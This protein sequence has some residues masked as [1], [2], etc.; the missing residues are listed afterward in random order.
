MTVKEYL[1]AEIAKLQAELDALPADIHTME[2]DLWV[3]IKAFFHANPS[4]AAPI[5][6]SL[7]PPA[8]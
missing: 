4:S 8:P 5:P 7:T 1:Q 6:T 2:Q 3:K